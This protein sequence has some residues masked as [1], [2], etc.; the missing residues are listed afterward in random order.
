MFSVQEENSKESLLECIEM[1]AK[2][3]YNEII[4]KKDKVK[5]SL[6][7]PTMVK[8][9]EAGLIKLVVARDDAGK[10]IAYFCNLIDIDWL[11]SKKSGKEIAIFVAPEYRKSGVFSEMLKLQESICLKLGVT[12]QTLEFQLNHNDKLPLS[13]GYEP[14]GIVYEKCLGGN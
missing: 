11:T 12:N 3:Q 13:H 10:C 4:K 14:T 9:L 7:I 2:A 1:G 5:L 6:D 8:V